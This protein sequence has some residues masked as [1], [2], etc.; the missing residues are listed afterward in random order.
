VESVWQVRP[1]LFSLILTNEPPI[2]EAWGSIVRFVLFLR[3]LYSQTEISMRPQIAAFFLSLALLLAPAMRSQSKLLLRN[4]SVSKTQIVFEYAGDLWIVA[5]EGGEARRLTTGV[6]QEFNPHFSPD[7]SLIAFSGEYDGNIDVYVVPASGGVPRRLTYHPSPD[8]LAGWTPDGKSV[9]FASHRDS[10]A[11]SSQLYTLALDGTLPTALPLGMA[12][13]GS[14][15]PDGSHIAYEPVFHWQAAWK[16]YKGGQTLKIW[17][18][19]LADSSIIEIPREN[20]NDFNP[21]WVGK[22]IYFLSDRKGAVSLWS[23]D[24]ASKT[25]GELLENEGLDLKSA[26]ATADAIVYEQFGSLHLYDIATGKSR[27]VPVTIAADL[28]EV[29][30]HFEKIKNQA[31]ENA[32]ISPTGQRAVFE[33]HGD[34]LTV[35]ADKGDIRNLTSSPAVADRDPSWSPDGKSI[36]Y[37]SDESGEYA[38]H[39]RDQNGLGATAKIN[40]GFPPSF[41]YSPTW[42]PDNKHIAYF[43]KRLNLWYIDLDKKVPVRI[44]T[45]LYDSPSYDFR[46]FWSP[47]SKW[48]AYARQLHNHLHA[49]FVYSLA[50]AK[51]TQ[52]TDGLSDAYGP[53]FDKTGKYLYFLASTNVA[54][55]GG[56]IDMTSIGHPVTSAVYLAVLRK[57]LPS[58]LA[59]L[60]DDEKEDKKQ[61][62]D[63]DKDDK[64]KDKDKKEKEPVKVSIDFDNIQQRIL[65]VPLPEKNYYAAV[66]GKEG[67]LFVVEKPLVQTSFGPPPLTVS[68]FD[69][70]TRKTDQIVSGVITYILADNGEKML[71]RQ[72]E[73]WFIT[74][75]EAALKPGDGLLKTADM[76]VY[77]DPRAEWKQM[78][79]EVWRIERDFLYDPHAHGLN[80]EAAQGFYAPWVESVSSRDDLNYLFQEMLGNI[81]IGHMFV[82]GGSEPDVPKVKVG[83]LGADYRR[84]NGRWRFAKIYDGENWNPE[85]QAPLTQPGVN[86]AAG[87]YLLAV[88]GRELRA[89]N[90][91]YSFF[92]ETAGKQTVLRVGSNPDGTGARDVTVIPVDNDQRLRHRA[93]VEGNRREVDRLSGGKIAYVH[94]PD[95]ANG[96]YTSFN[97]YYFAQIGKE[98]AVLD[99][100]Y[101]HGGDIADYIIEYLG[102]RPMGRIMTREGEDITDPVQAIYGPKVM[103][104]NQFAGSGGDAMPWY[105]RKAGLGPLVGMKTWGGLV[106]I[107]GYPSLLDGGHVTAP[108]WAFYG[109]SGEWEVE[110]HGIAPD[111]EID[112]DPKLI[113]QGR[114]PQLERAVQAAMELLEK[115]PPP[116]YKRPA[117]PNYHPRLPTEQ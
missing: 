37:F 82:G 75:A 49:I 93:W 60:S 34:I 38:L 21:M 30:P 83:L 52:L 95:T 77:V 109:L 67:I 45:D 19:D 111:I 70:K 91:L 104:I 46:P 100:R 73:Q 106:G 15:S 35:P 74:G 4:P 98:G 31:I 24:I 69:F 53:A 58:P 50:S 92:Q 72:G 101:N 63:K 88:N 7:G 32:A 87:E 51:T 86:V 113:R 114:D 47:D 62:A 41:F 68:K 76:Q 36:A 85:L 16:R 12:E 65:A 42:A 20:S 94:L 40:L 103:I 108:R 13:D 14:Y 27:P 5:R 9:L 71:I 54:L 96:G 64:D 61:D 57:D 6:G 33:A 1:D 102:R 28:A 26:C 117:Y 43:D 8:I 55:S 80:L 107:G 11:D 78:Y 116:T 23:Y 115:N 25:V 3:A 79:S 17:L 84:E 39:I 112:Q 22:K 97:R 66:P 105:F 89:A 18:A 90:N 2:F 81:N 44:D 56:W 29:R 110:N 10:F 59:P 99:E 48:I